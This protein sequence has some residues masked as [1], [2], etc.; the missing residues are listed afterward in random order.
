MVYSC[1]GCYRTSLLNWPKYYGRGL[2][3]QPLHTTQL[4]AQD[5]RSGRLKFK[6]KFKKTATYHD[7]CHL[8]RHI[9]LFEEPR[10]ILESIPG[11][12]LVEMERNRENS[13]CCGAGG[14]MK[15]LYDPTATSIAID[16]LG[17]AV[18]TGAEVLVTP[19]VFCKL[20]FL[21]GTKQLGKKID[22]QTIE[23]LVAN[24]L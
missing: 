14:G 4:L 24:L 7:P 16:R 11:L 8:G 23:E 2:P 13:R 1:S 15:S 19:C 9:G 17:E 21:D 3:F 6:K 10:Y 12:K 22:V 5:I 18:D 20:N